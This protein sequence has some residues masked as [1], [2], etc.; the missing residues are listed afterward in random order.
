MKKFNFLLIAF[1]LIVFLFLSGCTQPSSSVCPPKGFPQPPGCEGGAELPEIP[2]PGIPAAGAEGARNDFGCFPPSCSLIPDKRGRVICEQFKLGR[3]VLFWPEK[4]SDMPFSCVNLCESEKNRFSE[5]GLKKWIDGIK[6]NVNWW[7]N[8]QT[9]VFV[10]GS[11][12]QGYEV[13]DADARAWGANSPFESLNKL[14]ESANHYWGMSWIPRFSYSSSYIVDEKTN[15]LILPRSIEEVP[16]ELR[17]ALKKKLEGEFVSAELGFGA[18]EKVK[19]FSWIS[20]N[21]FHPSFINHLIAGFKKL[22]DDGADG[23]ILDDVIVIPSNEKSALYFDDYSVS[24]FSSYLR[25]K[26]SSEEWAALGAVDSKEFNYRDFLRSKGFSSSSFNSSE[27]GKIPLIKEFR[28]FIAEKNEQ[29]I[30]KIFSEVKSYAE[31]K[32]RKITFTANRADAYGTAAIEP[33][34]DYTTFEYGFLT[35]ESNPKYV[36]VVSASKMASVNG[37]SSL[38]LMSAGIYHVLN[39]LWKENRD[40]YNDVYR[41]AIMESYASK[42][43]HIYLRS[44]LAHKVDFNDEADFLNFIFDKSDA[45][46]VETAY[47]FM[48]KYK[49]YFS[50]FSNSNAK[51]AVIYDSKSMPEMLLEEDNSEHYWQGIRIINS[52]YRQGFD[53]DVVSLDSDYSKYSAI[54]LP[55]INFV[56]DKDSGKLIEFAD[57]GGKLILLRKPKGKLAD[58]KEGSFGQGNILFLNRW[59]WQSAV[60]EAAANVSSINSSAGLA[61]ISYSNGSGEHVVHL[62]S[63]NEGKGF[64][65]IGFAPAKNVS[66]SLPFNIEGKKVFYASLENPELIELDSDNVVIPE[67]KS[68]GMLVLKK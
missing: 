6:N 24:E 20:Y 56:D 2:V 51:I 11:V 43:S 52:L 7:S 1:A 42:A 10:F 12:N 48:R 46:A 40:A 63:L 5:G 64:N 15:L 30:K 65:G 18:S 17:D 36:S 4:C 45:E 58:L 3:D 53:A 19:A 47:G 22:V 23:L 37:K 8:P 28:K 41:L 31:S 34:T 16:S 32:G 14:E 25:N 67:I 66:V 54:V 35:A 68:Y 44:T 27:A 55:E 59:D 26:L 49:N 60:K 33:I 62:F 61:A 21:G 38:N 39:N 29:A 9:K 13:L 50:D 57:K